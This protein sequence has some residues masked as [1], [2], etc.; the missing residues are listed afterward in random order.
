MFGKTEYRETGVLINSSSPYPARQRFTVAHEL[1]HYAIPWHSAPGYTC[2][3]ADV[4][5]YRSTKAAEHEANEFASELLLPAFEVARYLR[6]DS[7]HLE[8]VEEVANTFGVSLTAAAV[9]MVQELKHGLCSVVFSRAGKVEWAYTSKR[10]GA[11]L[12]N[13]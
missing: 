3:E 6:T 10:F 2:T 5:S 9:K 13:G 11:A 7:L 1:G 12:W 4:E 8:L